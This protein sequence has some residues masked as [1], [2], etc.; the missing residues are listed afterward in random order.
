MK[1]TEQKIK[2]I[3]K[4]HQEHGMRYAVDELVELLK[5]TER[6][7]EEQGFLRGFNDCKKMI[8]EGKH[9]GCCIK[10]PKLSHSEQGEVG[11]DGETHGQGYCLKCDSREL[12]DDREFEDMF[13]ENREQDGIYNFL[14]FFRDKFDRH[15]DFY[16][17][18]ADIEDF[19]YQS[20]LSIREST[21]RDAI[22]RL[23]LEKVTTLDPSD[24]KEWGEEY[25]QFNKDKVEM[26]NQM[27]D[28]CKKILETL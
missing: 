28:K 1:T 17:N 24:P 19:I 11:C 10:L 22:V 9:I 26:H 3:L 25:T 20:L 7:A 16:N 8:E 4:K 27:I 2:Q 13:G 12:K 15:D 21:L 6:E 14:K 5:V 23:E 18:Y